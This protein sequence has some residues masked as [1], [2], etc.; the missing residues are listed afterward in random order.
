MDDPK[1]ITK[2]NGNNPGFFHLA[3]NASQN[4]PA[5]KFRNRLEVVKKLKK[6]FKNCPGNFT[7]CAILNLLGT[8]YFYNGE[9]GEA[10]SHFKKI[11][12]DFDAHN[13]NAL[14][15]LMFV[16]QRIHMTKKSEEFKRK[17][18]ELG[19]NEENEDTVKYTAEQAFAMFFDVH[20]EKSSDERNSPPFKLLKYSLELM[21]KSKSSNEFLKDEIRYWFAE[22]CYKLYIASSRST[23][24]EATKDQCYKLGVENMYGVLQN[25]KI[26]NCAEFREG[27]WAYLGMFMH[28]TPY[29][30]WDE[31]GRRVPVD[32]KQDVPEI[33]KEKGLVE[34][35][36]QWYLCF[37]CFKSEKILDC[38]KHCEQEENMLDFQGTEICIRLATILN[39]E[40]DCDK[41]LKYLDKA[42]VIDNTEGNWFALTTK[43]RC[44]LT[45]FRNKARKI[46]LQ[47]ESPKN[48][49][50]TP[51]MSAT[52]EKSHSADAEKSVDSSVHD[53]GHVER[54]L[55]PQEV[56]QDG[57]FEDL[58]QAEK[59]YELAIGMNP[60]PVDLSNLANVFELRAKYKA[61]LNEDEKEDLETQASDYYNQAVEHLGKEK[62]PEIHR[63]YGRFLRDIGEERQA[64][65]CFKRA[66]EVDTMNKESLSFQQL[67]QTLILMYKKEGETDLPVEA[68]AKKESESQDVSAVGKDEEQDERSKELEDI[69]GDE[70][71]L[72]EPSSTANDLEE[73][74]QKSSVFMPEG[75]EEV[76]TE[77]ETK[78]LK[79]LASANSNRKTML[80]EITYWL[81]RAL[82][83]NYS[84]MDKIL[85]GFQKESPLEFGMIM[86]FFKVAKSDHKDENESSNCNA[87]RDLLSSESV[88]H[89]KFK[90]AYELGLSEF[91][92]D[93]RVENS[94]PCP[95]CQNYLRRQDSMLP[96]CLMSARNLTYKF[97]FFIIFAPKEKE[98]VFYSL[99]KR[100]E[101]SYGYKGAFDE[102]DFRPGRIYLEEPHYFL[103][104][105]FKALVVLSEDFDAKTKYH[106]DL[107]QDEQ[108]KK[109]REHFIIPILR[110][111]SSVFPQ[112]N[113][114]ICL[115]AVDDINWEK[116]IQA[117]EMR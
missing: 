91:S 63:R 20:L 9:A 64:M 27:A 83:K 72:V 109:N 54:N 4:P 68:A 52:L 10:I 12:K 80:H 11:I 73:D 6:D 18:S 99:L 87:V 84:K 24:K 108:M 58:H 47:K 48:E 110:S 28:K 23:C 7:N 5:L 41:A 95:R 103:E 46:D 17:L 85:S 35:Y 90:S 106:L 3:L 112:L 104:N 96:P 107:A 77:D 21:G 79:K 14:A 74:T 86:S 66:M 33:V 31:R 51:Q 102:R 22:V 38:E 115:N 70:P 16:Y 45:R 92:K 116:L 42:W 105:S 57:D 29:T 78:Y 113:P 111:S 97:D 101:G 8:L 61:G 40:G 67:F 88:E 62:R 36:L 44:L 114:L 43:A 94:K 19:S 37:R 117:L 93:T 71:S 1:L 60:T 15:N 65:E 26:T 50:Q 100:L 49:N 34:F 69:D 59:D 53:A 89:K 13:R 2:I 30:S 56:L 75:Q 82:G 81:Q 39:E 55:L 76:L 32:R 98:W 25:G